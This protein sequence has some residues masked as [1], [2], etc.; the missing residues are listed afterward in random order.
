VLNSRLYYCPNPQFYV[1]TKSGVRLMADP[2]STVT[3]DVAKATTFV[4]KQ[5]A[6]VVANPKKALLAAVAYTVAVAIVAHVL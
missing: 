6:W 1:L 4:E 2:I 3:A 5:A